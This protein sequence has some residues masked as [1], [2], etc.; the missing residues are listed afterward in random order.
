MSV[1]PMNTPSFFEFIGIRTMMFIRDREE[2]NMGNNLRTIY[3]YL[4]VIGWVQVGGVRASPNVWL[5]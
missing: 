1:F 4:D 3:R 2:C 5:C